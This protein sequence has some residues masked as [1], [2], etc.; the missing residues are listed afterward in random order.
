M[1]AA[2]DDSECLGALKTATA[3][4]TAG[5]WLASI[6]AFTAWQMRRLAMAG[7]TDVLDAG[8]CDVD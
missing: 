3:D 2:T 7:W 5:A 4:F 1:L 6:F 8:R